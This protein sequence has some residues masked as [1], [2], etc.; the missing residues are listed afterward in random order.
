[1]GGRARRKVRP[2][3]A[4]R[5]RQRRRARRHH[6]A[7]P[8]RL[9]ERRAGRHRQAG[10]RRLS[11]P[12]RQSGAR[13][14]QADER[15]DGRAA[16]PGQRTSSIRRTWSSPRSTSAT[17]PSISFP[18]RRGRAST[19]ASTIATATRR[20]KALVEQR[21]AKAAGGKVRWRDRL[22]AVERR[23]VLHR[24]GPVHR[25]GGRR[26]RRGDRHASRSCRPPAARRTRASSRTIARWW[27]SAWSARPCT[28][29]T[30]ACR[31]RTL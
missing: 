25:R 15:A 30:S 14:G 29:S 17:R 20:C 21:A 13:A 26:G 2:L 16:R 12:R 24:A 3:H 4:G 1:M 22:G 23:R 8:P 9:A 18:A 28:P 31:S 5:A 6:Q 11:A 27:S 7:R 19:S 10:P